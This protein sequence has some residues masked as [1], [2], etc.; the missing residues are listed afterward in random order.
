MPELFLLIMG[1]GGTAVV[2]L[3]RWLK[4][5][6]VVT[7]LRMDAVRTDAEL[8]AAN[9]RAA[10]AEGTAADQRVLLGDMT[11]I[12]RAAVDTYEIVRPL[13]DWLQQEVGWRPGGAP[14]L[15]GAP[16]WGPSAAGE[17]EEG[18]R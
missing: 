10:L 14:A 3:F 18:G 13:A 6:Q 11:E 17:L 8:E 4:G 9:R 5:K 2:F 16:G 15:P 1:S 7:G 12:A